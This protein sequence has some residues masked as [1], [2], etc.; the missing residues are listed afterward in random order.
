MR[1]AVRPRAGSVPPLLAIAGIVA[2]DL[3]IR[4]HDWPLVLLG[5]LDESAH[6]LTAWLALAA[7]TARTTALPGWPWVLAGAVFIDLDHVPLFLGAEWVA[8]TAGGRPVTHSLTT[9][10]VLLTAATTCRGWRMPLIG[11]AAGVAL[12]LARDIA[13]GP[14]VPLFWPLAA[15][16]TRLPYWPYLVVLV[17]LA[18][19]AVVRRL[20]EGQAAQRRLP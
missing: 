7:L 4:A 9:V 18:T 8:A 3:V 14:G 1:S 11:L 2:L 19:L 20:P 12:H 17:A 15:D 10:V 6:L 16:D 13:T 5:V